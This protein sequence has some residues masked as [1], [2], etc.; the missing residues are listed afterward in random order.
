MGRVANTTTRSGSAA[1]EMAKLAVATLRF[2]SEKNSACKGHSDQTYFSISDSDG[3][4]TEGVA[5]ARGYQ[6]SGSP[7]RT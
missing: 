3:P 2:G 7:V 6:S 4:K 1:R 5:A